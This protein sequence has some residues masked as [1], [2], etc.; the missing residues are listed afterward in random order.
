MVGCNIPPE[1]RR[2]FEAG[3]GEV[4]LRTWKS[5]RC[6]LCLV[7]RIGVENCGC[8]RYRIEIHAGIAILVRHPDKREASVEYPYSPAQLRVSFV[9]ESVVET[10][11]GRESHGA[12]RRVVGPVVCTVEGE[13]C[14]VEGGVVVWM[15]GICWNIDAGSDGELQSRV[16]RPFILGVESKLIP[17]PVRFLQ[18][19]RRRGV[20]EGVR[21]KTR[22]TVRRQVLEEPRN[23]TVRVRTEG[24]RNEE[25]PE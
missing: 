3:I 8:R 5:G 10:D 13:E 21:A 18:G 22:G 23:G 6:R 19:A 12:L 2:S 15:G 20:S 25:V 7:K 9:I 24:I 14:R 4:D 16:H 17:F 1:D 11:P